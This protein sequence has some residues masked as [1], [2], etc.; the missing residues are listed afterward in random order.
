MGNE[1]ILMNRVVEILRFKTYSDNTQKCYSDW[2]FR[3]LVFHNRKDSS[4]F[5]KKEIVDFISFLKKECRYSFSTIS[6]AYNA[7]SFLYKEVLNIAI[8]SC[9]LYS[10]SVNKFPVILSQTE[11]KKILLNLQGEQWLMA[12]ILYGSGLCLSECVNLRVRNIDFEAG[13]ILVNVG[14]RN[15]ARE[16]I[17][18]HSLHAPIRRHLNMLKFQHEDI[19]NTKNFVGAF[20]PSSSKQEETQL[21]KEFDWHYL[22]PSDRLR[23]HKSTGALIQYSRSKSYVQKS[24]KLAARKAGIKKNA[25]CHSFRHSFASH[26]IEYGCDIHIVQK[27]LGHKDIQTTMIYAH[28]KDPNEYN[29]ESP[30]DRILDHDR[31]SL[32]T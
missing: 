4:Q 6:I 28:L 16:T 12:S 3:F 32:I 8:T 24:I 14:L 2:I 26:L 18:P 29:I 30:L 23:V 1:S 19:L 11:I 9:C 17:L 13:K 31:I 27:L 21:S 20:I 22:F 5:G 10:N 15:N 25:T 7:V